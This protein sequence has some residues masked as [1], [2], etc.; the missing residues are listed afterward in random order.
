MRIVIN[1]DSNEVANSG[2]K[3]A[4]EMGV[5]IIATKSE[6]PLIQE[7]ENDLAQ[8]Y[9][10]DSEKTYTQKTVDFIKKRNPYIPVFIIISDP[11]EENQLIRG[12]DFY[13]FNFLTPENSAIFFKS[14]FTMTQKYCENFEKLQNIVA[15]VKDEIEFAG[16]KYDPVRRIFSNGSG[17]IKK[18]SAKEGGVLEILSAN[19]GSVVKKE[20][21]MEK[22]WHKVDFYVSRS[23]DVYVTNIRNLFK[24]KN[25]PL[26]INSISGVGLILEHKN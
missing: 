9:I 8:C 5:E 22:V 13:V 11:S 10:L 16:Y 7:I 20:I 26:T 24:E 12:S 18:M 15:Q 23:M 21:I 25:I 14:I 4:R 3:L 1:T 19:Y 2:Y 17:V 6:K